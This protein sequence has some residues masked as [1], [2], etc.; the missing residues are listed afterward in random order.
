V[1]CSYND[2]ETG[3][4]LLDDYWGKCI[5]TYQRSVGE[6]KLWMKV[7]DGILLTEAAFTKGNEITLNFIWRLKTNQGRV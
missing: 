5:M 4:P 7:R 1:S 3:I 6:T 2:E